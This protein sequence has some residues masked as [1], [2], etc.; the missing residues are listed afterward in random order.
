MQHLA[1]LV[2]RCRLIIG[3]KKKIKISMPTGWSAGLTPVNSFSV[4]AEMSQGLQNPQAGCGA[5]LGSCTCFGFS[6]L[7]NMLNFVHW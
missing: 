5:V 3:F 1:G 7:H 2:G 6:K 4:P